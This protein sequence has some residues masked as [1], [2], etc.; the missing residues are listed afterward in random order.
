MD[1]YLNGI[2]I[3]GS[4]IGNSQFTMNSAVPTDSAKIGFRS[5]VGVV[6]HFQGIMDE[7]RIWNRSLS[8]DEIREQ[9]C[10]KLTGREPGLIGY[11]NFDDTDILIDKSPNHLNGQLEGNPKRV[12]SG[13]PIGDKS[14]LLY[15]ND[16]HD[17][18]LTMAD[19]LDKATVVNVTG[20][21]NGLHIY[22]V[23]NFPSQSNGLNVLTVAAPYFGVFVASNGPGNSFDVNYLYNDSAVCALFTRQD[24]SIP[25]WNKSGSNLTRV[26][27]RK[28][29]IKE[30]AKTFLEIDL[31][32]DEAPCT[33]SPRKLNPLSDSTGFEFLWQDGSKLSTFKVSDF[34]TYWL[35]VDDGCTGAIDTLQ[36]SKV[37]VD[38][39]KI[40]NVI[41]P[42]G[43]W[44]NDRFEIDQRMVGGSLVIYNRWGQE[45]YQSSNY[46]NDWEGG[47]LPAGVYFYRLNGGYCINEKRGTLSILR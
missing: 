44:F 29:F 6:Y 14:V 33:L 40:P 31:G 39:L 32:P 4:Y 24:N 1:L 27:E 25:Y 11:W 35:T 12:F 21:P 45:V 41:T 20:N 47:D 8:E 36:I 22:K 3:G 30:L 28:E 16:W 23:G 7:L 19:S 10:R 46:Q 15:T 18:T 43:D 2:N 17:K 13:A 37:V 42:N 26:S 34:G 9:M 38:S 5:S